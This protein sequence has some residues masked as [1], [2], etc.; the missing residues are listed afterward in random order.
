MN[1]PTG[2]LQGRVLLAVFAHPDDESLACGGC[3]RGA[4]SSAL[5]CRFSVRRGVK[6]AGDPV[7]IGSI[8]RPYE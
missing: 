8:P 3:W 6:W 2:V 1:S 4:P 7:A 5:V